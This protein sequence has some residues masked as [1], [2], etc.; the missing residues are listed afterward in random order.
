MV[1]LPTAKRCSSHPALMLLIWFQI[2]RALDVGGLEVYKIRRGA[3]SLPTEQVLDSVNSLGYKS[4]PR[5]LR[6]MHT[7]EDTIM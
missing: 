5:D 7:V 2:V 3:P 1:I 6:F 4:V